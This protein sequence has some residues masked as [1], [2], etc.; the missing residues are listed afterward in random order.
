MIEPVPY[1]TVRGVGFYRQF[2]NTSEWPRFMEAGR[3]HARQALI[4]WDR[5]EIG[6]DHRRALGRN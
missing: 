5:A 4:S 6:R 3:L 1:E 2:L